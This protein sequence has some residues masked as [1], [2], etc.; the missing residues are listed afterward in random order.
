MKYVI[1]Y[2]VII[3]K[4]VEKKC[5]NCGAPLS[6]KTNDNEITCNYCKKEFVIEKE[7]PTL[8]D[9]FDESNYVL[10]YMEDIGKTAIIAKIIFIV[11]FI[12]AFCG[13]GFTIYKLASEQMNSSEKLNQTN[14]NNDTSFIDNFF[15]NKNQETK[16]YIQ[17]YNEIDESTL[18]ILKSNGKDKLE[19]SIASHKEHFMPEITNSWEY[20]GSYF[21]HKENNSKL[22]LIYKIT[23]NID[24][25]NVDYYS[26][27]IVNKLEKKNDKVVYS[28]I[29]VD[30]PMKHLK[31]IKSTFG[32]ESIEKIYNNIIS[33]QK[34][35]YQVEK[36]D[37]VF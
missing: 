29:I 37:N 12:I 36:I 27:A 32:Y 17:K 30:N 16:N 31:E 20:T 25:Q 35:D 26:T 21:L 18:N 19:D 3:M 15:S 14:P 24:N 2:S 5:P 33:N 28:N 23:Y 9:L 22:Y 6:F 13:I 1:I 11:I 8:E 34:G 4:L 7:D 10:N